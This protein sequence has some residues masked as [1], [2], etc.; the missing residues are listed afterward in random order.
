MSDSPG[1]DSPGSDSP[2]GD[3]LARPYGRVRTRPRI[4]RKPRDADTGTPQRPAGRADR[5][6]WTPARYWIS[7]EPSGRRQAVPKASSWRPP[8][9]TV[10]WNSRQYSPVFLVP[11]RI[12]VTVPEFPVFGL[13]QAIV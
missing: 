6:G 5:D 11:S 8:M 4:K 9:T 7:Q 10:C 3:R 13:S 1:S 12:G 2:G